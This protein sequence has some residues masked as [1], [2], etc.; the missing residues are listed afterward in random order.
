MQTGKIFSSLKLFEKINIANNIN[1]KI[2]AN[3][4]NDADMIKIQLN[5]SSVIVVLKYWSELAK[6]KII[7]QNLNF[8]YFQKAIEGFAIT[9]I[10]TIYIPMD[11]EFYAL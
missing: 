8:I 7:L 3:Y 1:T 6:S 9:R 10:Y 11:R 4:I 5:T 2:I